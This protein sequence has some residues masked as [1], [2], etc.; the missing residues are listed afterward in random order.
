[1]VHLGRALMAFQT[2]IQT[3]FTSAIN[4]YNARDHVAEVEFNFTSH[5]ARLAR[6]YHNRRYVDNTIYHSV[7]AYAATYKFKESLY[8]HLRS[9]YNPCGRLVK[10]EVSKILGDEIDYI[11]FKTGAVIISGA[12]DTLLESIRLIYKWSNMDKLKTLYPRNG[13][14]MGDSPLKIIDDVQSGKVRIEALDPRKVYEVRFDAVGN[15]IYIDIRYDRWDDVA[16]NWYEYKETI[17]KEW[18]R[19]YKGGELFAYTQD[20]DGQ[21]IAEWSNPYGF[22]PVEWTQHVDT[23]LG[24]GVTSFHHVR[25]KIDNLNDVATLLHDNVRKVVNAKFAISGVRASKDSDGNP[26]LISTTD[27]NRD[28]S[29]FIYMGK[30]GKIEAIK[31]EL[32][33]DGA[34]NVKT[35]LQME[36]ESDLPQLALQRMRESGQELSGVAIANMYGDAIDIFLDLQSNYHN[37]LK[38][39]TQMA[40]SIAAFRGYAGFTSYSLDSFDSGTIDF[41]IRT[42]ELFKDALSVKERLELTNVALTSKAPELM[43][44][45]LN[46]DEKE[47][48]DALGRAS[49]IAM[50]D[51][52]LAI[53]AAS[54][55]QQ[56]ANA[57]PAPTDDIP[58]DDSVV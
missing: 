17:D 18:F 34:L 15:V 24:F 1:M 46:Y 28:K 29:P 31:S 16:N 57:L 7:N 38:S 49:R 48:K 30:D 21:D 55:N 50:R 58:D 35:S 52:A 39:A 25:H 13:A 23:G 37:G 14:E 33:I 42:R 40:I 44:K 45:Q 47:I 11:N 54:N 53:R 27:D 6:Y 26:D 8:K 22:V 43:L 5:E 32:D 56:R 10:I 19:T 41:Q 20:G 3:G 2:G 51:N 9:L 4:T 36:I 12:D